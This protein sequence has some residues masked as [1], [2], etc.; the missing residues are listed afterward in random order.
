M[1]ELLVFSDNSQ[2]DCK[3]KELASS[4]NY[5]YYDLSTTCIDKVTPVLQ[6]L[7]GL[8]KNNTSIY[9][10]CFI[11]FSDD[12][13]FISSAKSGIARLILNPNSTHKI[14]IN[15][16]LFII[17]PTLYAKT[18]ESSTCKVIPNLQLDIFKLSDINNVITFLLER[19]RDYLHLSS[20]ELGTSPPFKLFSISILILYFNFRW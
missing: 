2:K 8:F 6:I 10:I 14:K 18:V 4:L 15:M 1:S 16:D 19:Y 12:P 11:L 17:K 13:D 7:A 9:K 20:L 5:I 3:L